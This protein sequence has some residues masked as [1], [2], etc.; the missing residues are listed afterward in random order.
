MIPRPHSRYLLIEGEA[1]FTT[2]HLPDPAIHSGGAVLLCPPFGWEEVCAYRA[3]REW[4]LELAA[5]GHPTLRISYPSTGDSTGNVDDPDRLGAWT[6][7]VSA[8]ARDLRTTVGVARVTALGIGLGGL[9]AH[10]AAAGGAPIDDLVLW[11]APARGRSIVRQLRAFA[12]LEASIF[13]EDLPVPE[14]LSEGEL[15]AGGFRLSAETVT[16][17]AG[18]DLTAM[19]LPAAADRRVLLLQRDGIAAD[20][21]LV[22][23]MEGVGAAVTTAPGSGY[24]AMTSHPQTTEAPREVFATVRRWLGAVALPAPPLGGPA[25]RTAGVITITDK[26]LTAAGTVRE[27]PIVIPHR[28]QTLSAVLVTPETETRAELA[29]VL[30]NAGAVRRIGPNRMWVEA[31][32]RW[33]RRGVPV[34]RLDVAG[35]GDSDGD[36]SGYARDAGLYVPGLVSQVIAALDALE[37]SGVAARFVVGGL[38]AGAF[39]AFHAALQDDRVVSAVMINPRALVWNEDLGAARDLRALVNQPFSLARLRRAATPERRRAVARWLLGMPGRLR[40]HVTDRG[41]TG[42]DGDADLDAAIDRF[43]RSGKRALLLFGDHEPLEAELNRSG[44]MDRLRGADTLALEQIAVRD[45][46][47]RPAWAQARAHEALDRSLEREL[48][49]VLSA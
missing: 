13:F 24:L 34:L 22:E 42:R 5:A 32:R 8:A 36:A 3:L 15:E 20:T 25:S 1:S 6:A 14:L 21:D 38:C 12:R 19:P 44:R 31:A 40:D 39:W 43:V 4:A 45:H 2:L 11:G 47:L 26:V 28:G 18:V 48:G 10:L 33:A 17:L 37:L 27:T 7:A 49:A 9:L 16:S 46:T 23:A 30:L 29:V 35:I 41:R